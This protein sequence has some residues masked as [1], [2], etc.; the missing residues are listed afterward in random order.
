MHVFFNLRRW[1]I[2]KNLILFRIN[3]AL[4]L[5]VEFDIELVCNKNHNKAIDF[6]DKE[7]P[8]AGSNHTCVAVITIDSALKKEEKYY[9]QNVNTLKKK[10]LGILL[11]TQKFL[12][13]SLMKNKLGWFFV[14]TVA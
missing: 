6:H 3:S 13:M 5:N 1:L 11:E 14:R 8:K 12:L 2:G 4:I 7:I 9:P 10:W